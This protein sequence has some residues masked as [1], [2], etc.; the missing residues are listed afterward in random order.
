MAGGSFDDSVLDA[1]VHFAIVVLDEGGGSVLSLNLTRLGSI[2]P[3]SMHLLELEVAC[4]AR[5]S[6]VFVFR[7][8]LVVVTWHGWRRP[9]V[10]VRGG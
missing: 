5:R 3:L 8:D 7:L 2:A 1:V 9:F 6:S 10:Q 4:S